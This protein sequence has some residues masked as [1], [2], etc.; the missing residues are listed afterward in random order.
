MEGYLHEHDRSWAVVLRCDQS[1]RIR[2][3]VGHGH[4]KSPKSIRTSGLFE[5]GV[6]LIR[7]DLLSSHITGIC[8]DH[9]QLQKVIQL[10]WSHHSSTAQLRT[11]AHHSG[12]RCAHTFPLSVILC[13]S[14][15]LVATTLPH[16]PCCTVSSLCSIYI[17]YLVV[18]SPDLT[19]FHRT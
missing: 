12:P 19:Y 9:V 10:L 13:I 1:D 6:P 5:D 3:G 16:L 18:F 2:P 11:S 14:L 4:N 15:N 17:F 7:A 8:Q